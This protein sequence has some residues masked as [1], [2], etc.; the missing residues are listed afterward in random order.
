MPKKIN[1][2]VMTA[3]FREGLRAAYQAA[4]AEAGVI[5]SDDQIKPHMWGSADVELTDSELEAVRSYF[6]GDL[7]E[8]SN[9]RNSG[10]IEILIPA[11]ESYLA[12]NRPTLTEA[13]RQAGKGT[14]NTVSRELAEQRRAKKAELRRR[15]AELHGIDLDSDESEE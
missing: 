9:H 3:K 4:L 14:G 1:E 7:T 11:G 10:W 5:L 13:E 15:L 2:H 8:L 12:D 6:E